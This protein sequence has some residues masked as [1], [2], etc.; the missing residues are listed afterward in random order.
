[1]H[2][3]CTR[4]WKA[5]CQTDGQ[6]ETKKD[7]YAKLCIDAEE[8]ESFQH[9][10]EVLLVYETSFHLDEVEK[11][12]IIGSMQVKDATKYAM[13]RYIETVDHIKGTGLKT[14]KTHAASSSYGV[15]PMEVWIK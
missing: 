13:T 2:T 3:I 15:Q 10:F 5:H 12:T 6:T 14:T 7:T 4:G 1:M 8:I 9:L 11:A